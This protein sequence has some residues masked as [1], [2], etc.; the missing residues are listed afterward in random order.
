MSAAVGQQQIEDYLLL[1]SLQEGC[2]HSQGDVV[3][4]RGQEVTVAFKPVP[5]SIPPHVTPA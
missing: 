4:T 5:Q 2:G 3:H 1:T